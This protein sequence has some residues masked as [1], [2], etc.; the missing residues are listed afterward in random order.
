MEIGPV[1]ADAIEIELGEPGGGQLLRRREGGRRL[2]GARQQRPAE[3]LQLFG[4][5][6]EIAPRELL[7]GLSQG[8]GQR[9]AEGQLFRVTPQPVAQPIADA[10]GFGQGRKDRVEDGTE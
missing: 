5:I 1:V 2:K 4:E 3:V 9:G 6:A 8:L 10:A 7:T